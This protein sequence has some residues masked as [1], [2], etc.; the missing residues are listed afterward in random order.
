MSVPGD[1]AALGTASVSGCV[2]AG[3]ATAA[4]VSPQSPVSTTVFTAGGVGTLSLTTPTNGGCGALLRI[5]EGQD[6]MG[7]VMCAADVDGGG[8]CA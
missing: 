1:G 4:G 8:V 2:T 7:G 6:K 5:M 3:G